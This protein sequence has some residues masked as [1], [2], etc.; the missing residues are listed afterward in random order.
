MFEIILKT[1]NEIG[2]DNTNTCQINLQSESARR[3]IADKIEQAI[4]PKIDKIIEDIVV[5]QTF[6]VDNS[7]CED[8]EEK[9]ISE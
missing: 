8:C 4:Q 3:M 5:G 2:C 1:L 7:D 6:S 9:I